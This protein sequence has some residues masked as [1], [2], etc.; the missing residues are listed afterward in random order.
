MVNVY[1]PGTWSR[2]AVW[3]R[4][5]QRRKHWLDVQ[6]NADVRV[7]LFTHSVNHGNALDLHSGYFLHGIYSVASFAFPEQ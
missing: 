6:Q 5:G 2:D 7:Y 1:Y 4:L 3:Q